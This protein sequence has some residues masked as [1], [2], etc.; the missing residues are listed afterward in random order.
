M[1]DY[2]LSLL[3]YLVPANIIAITIFMLGH[4]KDVRFH[5]IESLLSG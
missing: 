1:N 4:R 2:F 5:F 3:F